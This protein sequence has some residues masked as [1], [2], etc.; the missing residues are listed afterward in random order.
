M[1]TKYRIIGMNSP[2][3]D[4]IT[5][6]SYI[7]LF[8]L[9]ILILY[10]VFFFLPVNLPEYLFWWIPFPGLYHFLICPSIN[11]SKFPIRNLQYV[12]ISCVLSHFPS[13]I[14][15]CQ[16]IGTLHCGLFW[17]IYDSLFFCSHNTTQW[18][19]HLIVV[20]SG[21]GSTKCTYS[22]WIVSEKFLVF[23]N[24]TMYPQHNNKK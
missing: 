2:F 12:M 1:W 21:R 4:F 5:V 19:L 13:L 11:M 22:I 23:V 24:A 14:I 16:F 7:L 15:S 8:K 17:F 10:E 3:Q 20:F 9:L 18:S 6:N